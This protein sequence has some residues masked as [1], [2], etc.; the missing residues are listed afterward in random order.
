VSSAHFAASIALLIVSLISGVIGLLLRSKSHR[1]VWLMF[2]NQTSSHCFKPAFKRIL[3]SVNLFISLPLVANFSYNL[4]KIKHKAKKVL[5]N[6]IGHIETFR[7]LGHTIMANKEL[8]AREWADYLK[9]RY[10]WDIPD[11]TK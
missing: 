9:V 6:A 10:G 4:F 7:T 3:T 2:R 5:V 11:C 8:N 1:L